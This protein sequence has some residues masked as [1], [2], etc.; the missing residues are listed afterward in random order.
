MKANKT[1]VIRVHIIGSDT[2][3]FRQRVTVQILKYADANTFVLSVEP[4]TLFETAPIFAHYG[5]PLTFEF[6]AN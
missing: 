4:K 6:N 5:E 2:I 3:V 1:F